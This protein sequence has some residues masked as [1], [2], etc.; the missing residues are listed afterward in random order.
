MTCFTIGMEGQFY[1]N[2]LIVSMSAINCA[3]VHISNDCIV[4]ILN[5]LEHKCAYLLAYRCKCIICVYILIYA[6]ACN[7]VIQLT[8]FIDDS[9]TTH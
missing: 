9:P 5:I 8:L 2:Y 6:D 7:N 1:F 3:T 4:C